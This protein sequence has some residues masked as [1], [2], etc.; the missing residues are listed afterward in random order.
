[1]S[2]AMPFA[3]QRCLVDRRFGL[4]RSSMSFE[5]CVCATVPAMARGLAC[6]RRLCIV[7]LNTGGERVGAA[8]QQTEQKYSLGT[9]RVVGS[10]VVCVC[11][12]VYESAAQPETQ[13]RELP[14]LRQES[15]TRE[16][17]ESGFTW[18]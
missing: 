3:A 17:E 2:D 9:L 8:A 1:M 4:S 12:C 7:R 16:T 18:R 11:G 5:P 6:M 13:T 15:N 10:V 14:E